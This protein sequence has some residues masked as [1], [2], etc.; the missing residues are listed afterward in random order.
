MTL[1]KADES[2]LGTAAKVVITKESCTSEFF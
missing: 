2:C 1:D